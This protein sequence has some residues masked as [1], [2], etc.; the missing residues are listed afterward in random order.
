[1]GFAVLTKYVSI[2]NSLRTNATCAAVIS[3]N[4]SHDNNAGDK[5][6]FESRKSIDI[7]LIRV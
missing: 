3:N 6:K 5:K 2:N 1:M 4:E 7:C